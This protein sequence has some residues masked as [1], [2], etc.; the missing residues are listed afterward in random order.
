MDEVQEQNKYH[1]AKTNASFI[2]RSLKY[3]SNVIE[4]FLRMSTEINLLFCILIV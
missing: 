3:D 1:T 4:Q 2:E